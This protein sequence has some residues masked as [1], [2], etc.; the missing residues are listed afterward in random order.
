MFQRLKQL[1]RL[2]SYEQRKKILGLQVL[3]ILMAFAQVAGVAAIGPFMAVVGDISRLEGDGTLAQLYQTS[4]METPRQFLF[5]LGIA[6]LVALTGAALLSMYVTWRL[7]L[8]AEQIGA[9]LSTRLYRHY[10]QQP[11]LF[12]ASGSSSQLT[13]KIAQETSRITKNVIKPLMKM[14]AKVG[15]ALIMLMAIFLFNPLVATTGLALFSVSYFVLFRTV[16]RRLARNGK[17][18]SRNNQLRFK[19]M[20]E[21]FGGIKDTLLLGRQANFEQRFTQTSQELG[22]AKGV[23][24]G[25]A[26][27]PR[28]A[29]EL[30]AF[31]AVIFLVLYLLAAYDGNLGNILPVLSVYALAGFKLLPAF[32]QIYTSL[33]TVKG[34]MAAFDSLEEDLVASQAATPGHPA[35]AAG[36]LS[37]QQCIT[38]QDVHFRYPGK[39]EKAL[40]GLSLEIPRNHII[41]LV[42][43]SGSGKSTAID[44]LLGL[45]TPQQGALKVDG[46][47]LSGDRLRAWQ[48]SLGFV[49]QSIFLADASIREN[50]A[51][52]LPPSE[53][54][55]QRV[56]RAAKMAHLDELLER[57][58]EGLETRVGERGIQLSGGQRQRIGIARALY[59]DA[60]VLILDEATSALDGITEKL[61]MDAI[62]AFSGKKTIIMIAHRLATVRQCDAI[63]LL[64]GGQVVDHGT[65]DELVTNNAVFQR[66]AEHA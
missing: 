29:M 7:V 10:M 39:D 60:E 31:G 41:G 36:K 42:G 23:S 64:S 21:G 55:N 16:R 19:L 22:R 12:H 58:P 57:L 35:A 38:L 44:V 61:V 13:N 5:W 32:Q 40:N 8:Y 49:P 26:E 47:T 34:N 52:G 18:V 17:L 33:A 15:L 50:I 20:N 46:E 48:N 25:L 2:L 66:M 11:W 65:Y 3:V 27:V 54:D 63:Y 43:A 9:D 24:S 30:I 1:Y 62:H 51:F 14:N 4:G 59:D 37:A 6:V 28:Y 45:M 56:K 53:V